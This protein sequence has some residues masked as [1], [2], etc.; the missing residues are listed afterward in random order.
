MTHAELPDSPLDEV[1][2][3]SYHQFMRTVGLKTLKNRLAEYVRLAAQ[4]ENILISDRDRIVA[5]LSPPREYRS[6]VVS[7]AVI[8]EMVRSGRLTPAL[9]PPGPPPAT[10]AVA[11]LEELLAELDADREER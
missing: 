9:W 7:D 2:T 6:P 1:A 10:L 11:P 5:E 4:G 3:R 8:A